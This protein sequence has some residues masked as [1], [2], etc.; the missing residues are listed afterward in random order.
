MSTETKDELTRSPCA[1]EG[2]AL[3]VPHITP[4]VLLRFMKKDKTSSIQLKLKLKNSAYSFSFLQS[5][6]CM[7]SVSD[8][9]RNRSDK[10]GA[11]LVPIGIQINS[12]LKKKTWPQNT[13]NMLP[14]KK[15]KQFENACFRVL[16]VI[17]V[18]FHNVRLFWIVS[19]LKSYWS[20]EQ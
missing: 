2:Q 9:Y 4:I 7:K 19:I 5:C 17:R 16:F 11:Q 3:L 12:R 20:V 6:P 10:R 18:I 8:E 13:T 1:L 14:M 15:V